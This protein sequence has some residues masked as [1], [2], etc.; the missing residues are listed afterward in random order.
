V[1]SCDPTTGCYHTANTTPP[2]F[3]TQP[4]LGN[5]VLWPPNHGYADFTVSSTGATASSSCGIASVRFASCS[6]SQPENGNG[7]GDG[8][9]TRDCVY[10]PGALHLRAE[11]DGA[12]SPVGRVYETTLVAVDVCGNAAV[13]NAVDIGVWHDR[14]HQP[15]AG[16]IVRATHGSN[17]KDTRTGTNGTYGTTCGLGISLANGTVH[18]P[19]DEDPEMEIFQDVSLSVNSLRLG[20]ATG[21]NVVVT[22]TAPSHGSD[23]TINK[24]HVYR[25]SSANSL[26]ILIAEPTSTTYSYLDAVLNDG[27]PWEYKVS[28]V[29]K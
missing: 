17:T 21:G 25:R 16:T 22:W 2:V 12:C 4:T 23:V 10:E 28:A 14:G 13:S 7:V 27:G 29:I 1:D 8:N 26:W 15:T 6:S 5:I 3:T 20:K 24:Y 19:S 18:D 11:R 9:S